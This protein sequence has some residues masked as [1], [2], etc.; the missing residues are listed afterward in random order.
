MDIIPNMAPNHS[1]GQDEQAIKYFLASIVES[2]QDSVVSIDLNRLITTWNKSAERL[3]GFRAEEVMGKHLETVMLP[4]DFRALINNVDKI[5]REINVPI[6]ETVRFHKSGK[7][8]DLQ[9]ALSPVK[10]SR[11][12]VIGVSTI[13]RDITEA[14]MQEQLKDEFIAV[15]SHELKSPITAIK[16]YAEILLDKFKNSGDEENTSMMGKLDDQIDRLIQLT[17]TL[18]DTTRLS[19]G[20]IPITLETF[21]VCLLIKEQ[22]DLLGLLSQTHKI[23]HESDESCMVVADRKLI[24][25]VIT[26]LVT[27]AIK[28]SPSGDK[29]IVRSGQS[30]EGVLVSIQDF[31]IGIPEGVGDKLF[32][33][34]FRVNNNYRAKVPGMG[35]G[36]YISAQIVHKHGGEIHVESKEGVGSTFSF[37]LPQ[38]NR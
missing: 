11:G 16:A 1:A 34:Y 28:Y 3:Y 23:I 37:T 20:E 25:Q 17:K 27:N 18:L 15:A 6:Y 8:I 24:T 33:R 31:G 4:E 5:S 12:E 32:E 7:M 38:E 9:I 19:N 21:D 30:N 22:V 29:V 14:K 10:N 36:L 13:A 35:L 2:S 26:N